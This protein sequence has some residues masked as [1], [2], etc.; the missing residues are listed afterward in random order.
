MRGIYSKLAALLALVIGLMAVFAGGKVLLGQMP[1]YYVINWLPVYNYS[2]GLLSALVTSVLLWR[3][4][5]LA[6]PAA[7]TTLGLHSGV[8]ITL[9]VSYHQVVAVDSLRAMA[10]RNGAWILISLLAWVQVRRDKAVDQ[11][12]AGGDIERAT[13][14]P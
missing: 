8:M 14:T 2:V 4:H 1:D 11:E 3:R 7:L 6:L 12:P 13:S 9:Q 10:L 5:R